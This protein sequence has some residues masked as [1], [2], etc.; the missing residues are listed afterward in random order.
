MLLTTEAA[1]RA[2]IWH[3]ADVSRAEVDADL[4][5]A[6]GHLVPAGHP[7]DLVTGRGVDPDV[8]LPC[9][10]AARRAARSW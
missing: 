1:D 9:A 5:A 3:R 6:A 4:A 2:T 8:A 7:V 10:V